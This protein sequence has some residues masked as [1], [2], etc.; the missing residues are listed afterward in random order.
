MMLTISQ[1]RRSIQHD[2]IV[3]ARNVNRD[4]EGK[5]P[6]SEI[7]SA[8]R[9]AFEKF[10]YIT[11]EGVTPE[12]LLERAKLLDALEQESIRFDDSYSGYQI[13]EA[14]RKL[15]AEHVDA[16]ARE[17]TRHHGLGG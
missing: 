7:V 11:E 14:L 4:E 8:L 5:R 12:I 3:A 10:V 9:E 1:L 6:T 16:L 2:F 17:V 13:P 15:R